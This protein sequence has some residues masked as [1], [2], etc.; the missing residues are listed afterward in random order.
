LDAFSFDGNFP[1]TDGAKSTRHYSGFQYDTE[2]LQALCVLAH[3]MSR[4]HGANLITLAAS[5]L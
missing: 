4:D 2:P 3:S 1:N 5:Y